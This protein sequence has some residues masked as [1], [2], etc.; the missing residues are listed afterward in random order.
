MSRT[1]LALLWHMHQPD[2]RD[3]HSGEPTL[4]FVRLHGLRGYRDVLVWMEEQGLP[5]C[6]NLVP[7]LLEQLEWYAQGGEDP[8][9]RLARAQPGSL[10]ASALRDLISGHPRMWT[11]PHA[12]QLRAKV[13][14]GAPLSHQE[15]LDLQVWSVLAWV[16]WS[17][18]R[19]HP[20]LAG[21][22]ARGRDF[23]L[24]DRDQLHLVCAGILRELLVRYQRLAVG[25][26]STTP[27]C[28]PILPLLVDN[29]HASRCLPDFPEQQVD[30]RWPQDARAQLTLGKAR[31]EAILGRPIHGL[32]PSEGSVSPE[33]LPMVR[34]AGVTWLATDQGVLERS[35]REPGDH[36]QVWDLGGVH[37]LFRDHGLS[38]FLGFEAAGADPKA[39]AERFVEACAQRSGQLLIAL[40]GENPWEAF[41]DAGQA[42]QLA[43]GEALRARLSLKTPSELVQ[44]AQSAPKVHALHSGS[45]IH[46]D[47]AI[48]IGD[49]QDRA[50]WRL[51]GSAR[52]AVHA[53]GDPPEA[54]AHIYAAEGSDW[55]WWYGPEFSTPFA[56]AFDRLFR[57]H[58]RAAW[59]A[60]GL[61]APAEL[62]HPVVGEGAHPPLGPLGELPVFWP[63]RAGRLSLAA[64]AAMHSDT[65]GVRGLRYGQ[66]EA[67]IWVRLDGRPDLP[68]RVEHDGTLFDLD[69]GEVT[70]PHA[71]LPAQI[72]LLVGD[73]RFPAQGTLTLQPPQD[74]WL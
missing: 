70:L 58:L 38:D 64:G 9:L 28:H 32:W 7:S 54:L 20:E 47:F 35:Q 30:F 19:D 33:I 50:A 65:A 34:E 15:R 23:N 74:W 10:S 66:R 72:A 62:D 36:H 60:I 48:W 46:A 6:I 14:S 69:A 4:P 24:A 49:E 18:L 13:E 11:H 5:F 27:L 25:E 37:G 3:P 41:E 63:L 31:A 52:E 16:G 2:Y 39:A 26:L 12:A 56:P 44:A 8:Q 17:G 67:G 53:A 45:W 59:C 21:L 1:E 42:F 73:R 22:K 43:L 57:A 61:P 51:L 68:A 40:D 71:S 55:F 29:R